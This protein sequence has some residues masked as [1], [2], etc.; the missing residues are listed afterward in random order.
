LLLLIFNEGYSIV[1]LVLLYSS[2]EYSPMESVQLKHIQNIENSLALLKF[3][4]D[5]MAQLDSQN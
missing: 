5:K 2:I 3:K 4:I 1:E